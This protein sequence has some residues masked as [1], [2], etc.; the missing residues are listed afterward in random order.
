MKTEY[1]GILI[2]LIALVAGVAADESVPALPHEFWGTVT[3]DGSPAPAGTEITAMIGGTG[4]GSITTTKSGTYG[5]SSRYD[6]N[7]LLVL[8]NEDQ[9]GATIAF[10]VDGKEAG[11][12][13]TFTPNG[14]TRL[15]LSVGSAVTPTPTPTSSNGGG[16]SGGGGSPSPSIT[17]A[18]PTTYTGQAS[19]A[20]SKSGE[21]QVS[22]TVRTTD[23][24]GS[25][26]I[27]AGTTAR[28]RNGKPLGEVSVTTL[29]SPALPPVPA[30][31]TLG[32]ALTCG[33]DGA[34]FDPPI[35]LIFTLTEDEWSR[36]ADTSVL[37]V[38]WYNP[39]T[40]SWEEVAAT[41]DPATRTV[42]A[43]VSHFSTY[44]LAWPS[45]LKEVTVSAGQEVATIAP[46]PAETQQPTSEAIPWPFI[47]AGCLV[48]LLAVAGAYAW[49]KRG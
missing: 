27:A 18:A 3:I 28:D 12:T 26:T 49:K 20:T 29:D 46:P 34:T 23:G 21:V 47:G 38:V 17:S 2:L 30:G 4:C 45:V 9:A 8:A 16:G 7:R 32:L 15:D 24:S 37:H 11:Q 1:C 25:V 14:T 40:G 22:T 31:N 5:S 6:G 48:L 43:R 35:T 41:V 36:I 44:A 33:P 42:T 13:A 39:S 19:L 10:L